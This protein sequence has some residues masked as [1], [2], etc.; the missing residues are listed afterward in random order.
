MEE[1][2]CCGY[3]V[4][5]QRWVDMSPRLINFRVACKSCGWHGR[6]RELRRDVYGSEYCPVCQ[7]SADTFSKLSPDGR[8]RVYFEKV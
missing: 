6:M 1:V 4:R 3:I 7:V 5:R 8:V 2:D